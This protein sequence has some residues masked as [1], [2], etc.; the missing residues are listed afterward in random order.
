[1]RW[2]RLEYPS[3]YGLIRCEWSRERAD[4]KLSLTVPPNTT[5]TVSL[6]THGRKRAR[7]LERGV[8]VAG[9]RI[10]AGRWRLELEAGRHEFTAQGIGAPPVPDYRRYAE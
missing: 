4:L 7:L 2:V 8:P 9:A 10:E 3:P 5:A 6:P 1:M